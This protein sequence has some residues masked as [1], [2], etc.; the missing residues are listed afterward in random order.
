M[1][2]IIPVFGGPGCGKTEL[3]ERVMDQA[4]REGT[5]SEQVAF[6]TFQKAA[7]SSAAARAGITKQEYGSHWV[8]TLHSTCYKLLGMGHKEVVTPKRLKEFGQ[9]LGAPLDVSSAVEEDEMADLAEALLSIEKD[10]RKDGLDGAP[11]RVLGC[12]HLSRLACRTP[13]ELGLVRKEPHPAALERLGGFLDTRQ[14]EA[15]VGHYERW[16][17]SSDLKDFTDMLED[18][19]DPDVKVPDWEYAFVDEAQDLSPLQWAVTERLFFDGPKT[20]FL[21]GDDDQSIMTFQLASAH[22]YLSYRA[23]ASKIVHLR[24]THR[25]GQAIVD[26][27]ARVLRRL[28]EREIR[29]TLPADVPTTVGTLSRFNPEMFPAGSKLI[30]HRFRAGCAAIARD[31]I[32]RGIPFWNKRGIN[33]LGRDAEKASYRAF[34]R[35]HRQEEGMLVTDILPLINGIPSTIELDGRKVTLLRRGAKKALRE[36][37]GGRRLR[38]EDLGM[39]FTE[40]LWSAIKRLDWSVSGIDFPEYYATLERN[41]YD[42]TK[43]PEIVISTIHGEKGCEANHVFLHDETLERCMRDE[44]EHRLSYVGLT[45]AR[46]GLYIMTTP[47]LSWRTMHY[48][49]PL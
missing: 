19:L 36:A 32:A 43:M 49:Y 15:L 1:T 44:T 42:L 22:E 37:D 8:R 16:K 25:F 11:S 24:Q 12:Y 10:L 47:L 4:I 26:L 31:F 30:L 35:L 28:S 34:M 5:P 3:C 45:R 39:W 27:G 13:E 38:P 7:A 18:T 21:A 2:D 40:D 41:G 29:D 9:Q 46:L 17:A 20:T 14:Y 6:T 33:P 48:P 23:R